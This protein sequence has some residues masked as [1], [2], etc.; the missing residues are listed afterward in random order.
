MNL[1]E[2]I[3]H[4][5][6]LARVAGERTS[7]LLSRVRELGPE[8]L[9]EPSQLPSWSRLTI[10]C[11]LRYGSHAL[12][13]MTRDTLANRETS[14]YPD[15]RMA[16]RPRTLMP[17]PGESVQRVLDDWERAAVELDGEWSTVTVEQW[18]TDVIEP[19]GNPDLGTVPLARLA[20]ARLT[21]VEVHGTDLGIGAPDW[22][23]T[24]VAVG[25]PTRL[26]WLSARRSNHRD[27]DSSL[28]GSWLLRAVDG[29]AWLVT[30]DGEHAESRPATEDD[31]PT[32]V[33]EGTSRDLLA[34]LLGRPTHEPLR[35]MGD[36]AFGKLFPRAFPGP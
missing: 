28:S 17:S 27:F 8:V 2:D 7:A 25:L 26:R 31:T 36:A 3:A 29:P 23:T 5:G 13:R 4:A 30:V 9:H 35:A 21:E 24:L 19:A 18:K 22:S 33:I 16:Q 14:Y 10:V 32:A 34:L 6:E 20:L 11:H 15:G 12:L 1:M